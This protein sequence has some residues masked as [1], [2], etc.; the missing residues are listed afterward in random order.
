MF[1]PKIKVHTEG[2]RVDDCVTYTCTLDMRRATVAFLAGL[3]ETERTR[4][5]T[6]AGTRALT[7]FG[8]AVLVVRWFLDAT[9]LSRLAAD[10]GIGSSTAYRYLHEGIDALAARAPDLHTALEHAKAGQIS[11]LSLDGVLIPTD[12]CKTPGPTEGVDLWWSGKHHKHGGN[13]QVLTG[14]DGWPLWTSPVRPGREH[15]I[16]AARTHELIE[17]IGALALAGLPTLADLGYEG[18]PDALI[19]PIK[20]TKGR[21]LTTD[22]ETYNK[23]Q[24]GTRG[25]GERAHALLIMRFRTLRR[26][27]LC[28]WRIGHILRAALVLLNHE[29]DRTI[30]ASHAA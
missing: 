4:R 28:P 23:L 27:T 6:R 14:P 25:Q 20:K 17:P 26:I 24:R 15:D 19:L 1:S 16:T 2:L 30:P 8:Q 18:E 22:Q 10:H 3:L 29:H 13:I 9:R 11:H 21:K 12:R 5:G 7:C